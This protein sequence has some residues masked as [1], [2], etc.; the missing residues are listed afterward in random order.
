MTLTLVEQDALRFHLGYGNL[1]IG[2]EAYT[3]SGFQEL[4]SE[5]VSPYLSV[6]SETTATTDIAAGSNTVVTPVSMT[7]ITLYGQLVVDVADAAEI[8]VVKAVTITTFTAAFLKAHAASGY[9][10]STLRG[11]ARVRL[12][13]WD[14]DRAY[15]AMM[16]E[17]VGA[18]GGIKKADEVEFFEGRT[19]LKERADHY[20]AI[21]IVLASL[22]QVVPAWADNGAQGRLEAY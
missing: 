5:V 22:V 10:I 16:S 14:A 17:D 13:L 12:A 6:G 7:G 11:L 21:C 3:A 20:R 9:P 8:V 1:G 15:R 18:T 2:S 4:F 19:V